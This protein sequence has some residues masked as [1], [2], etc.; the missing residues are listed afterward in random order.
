MTLIERIR[1]VIDESELSSA[2]F[3]DKIGVQRSSISHILS[4]RNKPSLDFILKVLHAY[5]SVQS[6]WLLLG[7]ASAAPQDII[8]EPSLFTTKQP[9]PT[10]QKESPETVTTSERTTPEIQPPLNQEIER[11]TVFYSD[12][13]C[14]TYTNKK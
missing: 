7:K 2:A 13:T 6:E 14:S 12:G 5:P 11:V 8:K 9:T 10:E 3:A 1:K 4:G